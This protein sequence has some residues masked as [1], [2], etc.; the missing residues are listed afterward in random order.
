MPRNAALRL[1]L[2]QLQIFVAIARAGST[3]A[4]AAQIALSQSATSAALNELESLLGGKLFNRA[5]G[6]LIL[7][8]HGRSMLPRARRL[9][10][11]AQA[12]EAQ[13]GPPH[14][15]IAASTTTGNYVLPALIADYRRKDDAAHFA[16]EIGNTQRVARAVADFEADVGFIEG[17]TSQP[18]LD[19]IPWMTDELLVVASPRHR[20]ARKREVSVADL[21]ETMWLLREPGSGTREV[22]EAALLPRLLRMRSGGDFGSTEAIKQ[23][24]AEGLGI[25]CLSRHAVA[26]FVKLGRL[27]AL[28]TALPALRRPFYLI[29]AE[30]R[31]LTPALER[32]IAHCLAYRPRK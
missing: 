6:R 27:V 19:L 18:R 7:N 9:L 11:A 16:L 3:T 24:A 12:I 31:F 22:V 15:R 26:D 1:T 21:G 14:L 20:L 4:A 5:G 13:V 30:H 25:T 2:R 23:A 28:R 17:P 32:F 8:E 29:L 10:D